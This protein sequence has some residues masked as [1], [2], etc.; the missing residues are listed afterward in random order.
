MMTSTAAR[1]V[2]LAFSVALPLAA[3]AAHP[4]AGDYYSSYGSTLTQYTPNGTFVR[5]LTTGDASSDTRGIAFGPGGLY[6]VLSRVWTPSSVEVLDAQGNVLKTYAFA[7]WTGGL[8]T[9][10]NIRFAP[11]KDV[12]YVS[13]QDGV[14]RFPTQGTQGTKFIDQSS[15]DVAVMPDGD[16]LVADDYSITRYTAD[17]V[18]V[19]TS[20][21]TISDPL[22]LGPANAFLVDVRGIAYDPRT[23]TTFVTMLGYSDFY[24][25]LLALKGTTNELKGLTTY[26]YG[27]EMDVTADGHLLVGS[28]TQ[29]PGIFTF[30]DTM[31]MNFT[32]TGTLAIPSAVFVTSK[33][34][35]R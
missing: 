26:W 16:L 7:G 21:G 9:S 30:T 4:F 1:R 11:G 2:A 27:N 13:A 31:P 14:Y 29:A 24:F 20:I 33:K 34:P 10:G 18:Q 22:G 3:N 19:G 8:V 17:G 32:Q 15:T 5:D 25:Q 12:F 28:W 6:V 23:D 35:A